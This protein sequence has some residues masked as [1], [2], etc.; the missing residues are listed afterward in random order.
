MAWP[1][2]LLPLSR[3]FILLILIKPT[4]TLLEL[5]ASTIAM[6]LSA[7]WFLESHFFFPFVKEKM[8]LHPDSLA[9]LEGQNHIFLLVIQIKVLK[10]QTRLVPIRLSYFGVFSAGIHMSLPLEGLNKIMWN[11]AF[12]TSEEKKRLHNIQGQS[13]KTFH[14][15]FALGLVGY[16]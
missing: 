6:S 5:G 2:I 13:E 10:S 15:H 11:I 3:E 16:V 7:V 9:V 12:L 1:I 8:T 4:R 14:L